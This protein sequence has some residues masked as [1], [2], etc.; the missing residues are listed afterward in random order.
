MAPGSIRQFIAR[1][2]NDRGG[3]E[4][5]GPTLGGDRDYGGPRVHAPN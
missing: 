3:L 5:E 1:I 2:N 4:L